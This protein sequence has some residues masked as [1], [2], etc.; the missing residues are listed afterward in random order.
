MPP[1][2]RV[3]AEREQLGRRRVLAVVGLSLLLVLSGCSNLVTFGRQG[4]PLG[5]QRGWESGYWH[6]ESL[7]VNASDG[8]NETERRAVVARTMARVEVI[9]GLEFR[10]HVSVQVV[11][12]E[13]YRD[14]FASGFQNR[15]SG[16]YQAWN[17]QVWEALF[18]VDEPT[19]VSESFGTVFETAVV[20]F[21]SPSRGEIVIV[22]DSQTPTIDRATLAHEL[23][24]ALQD[25]HLSLGT[26]A[27]TQD[28]QLAAD[29]LV[30]GDANA[31]Q[32]E[33]ERRC[34]A[35]WNCLPRP[36]RTR[37]ERPADFNRGVFLVIYAPYVTGPEFVT[38]L[39]DRGGWPA[40]NDAYDHYPASTTQVIHPGSYP[41]DAP[42]S[43]TVPDRSTDRWERFDLDMQA[44]T[45]GEASIYT[46]FQVNGQVDRSGGVNYSHPLSAGWRGDAVVPYR[47]NGEFGYV[48]KTVWQ[49]ASDA[50]EF[51]SGYRGV[52]QEHEA[53]EVENGVFVIREGGFSDAFQVTRRDDTVIVVNAP[54]RPDLRDVHTPMD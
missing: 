23:V 24:H 43:V 40:V 52:L 44:D 17:E 27:R 22:S 50:R 45:V 28:A 25:Q 33:Y 29:A 46:M 49:T 19:N 39:R 53:I 36:E 31:V 3:D 48:W 32:S 20:G 11:S 26:R 5:D 14:E 9:R 34:G 47:R 21:Y 18:L 2:G 37:G 54:T 35:K 16:S 15:N 4:E 41:D 1:G 30:E 7:A 12:R 42:T 10:S 38:A 51:L 13:T 8:L 6:D